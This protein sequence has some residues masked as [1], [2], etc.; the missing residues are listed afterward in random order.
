MLESPT[1]PEEL[2]ILEKVREVEDPEIGMSLVDLGLIY[3]IEVDE[4]KKA[5]VQMTY[6]S[7]ACPAG[8][9]MTQEVHEA[10]LSVD[11]IQEAQV[12]VV[13]TPKWDPRTMA[14]EEVKM[15]LGIF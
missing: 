3:K 2:A 9:Q 10:C 11:G 4:D 7:M 15:D 14:S 6:T 5:K 13:W 1:K 12:E 8:P